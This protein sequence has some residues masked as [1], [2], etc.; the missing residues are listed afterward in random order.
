MPIELMEDIA[1]SVFARLLFRLFNGT[2][3]RHPGLI[4][5]RLEELTLSTLPFMYTT[6]PP[7]LCAAEEN[8]PASLI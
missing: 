6:K 1:A 3:S 4:L 5:S 7:L 8:Q 2:M